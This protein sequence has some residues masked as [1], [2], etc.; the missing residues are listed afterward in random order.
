MDQ[1]INFFEQGEVIQHA[2]LA[3]TSLTMFR[4]FQN[5]PVMTHILT[6]EIKNEVF[7]ENVLE[8]MMQ[9]FQSRYVPNQNNDND[10]ALCGYT[11]VLYM[12]SNMEDTPYFGSYKTWEDVVT[13]TNRPDFFHLNSFVKELP[14]I[15]Y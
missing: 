15:L 13:L 12:V 9:L 7:M 1:L 11:F 2:L 3:S 10:L 6:E 4:R 8:R 5:S 14:S